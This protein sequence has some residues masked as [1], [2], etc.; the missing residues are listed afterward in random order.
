MLAIERDRES[1]GDRLREMVKDFGIPR[2]IIL[3]FLAILITSAYFLKLPMGQILSSIL[4]R[5]GMNGVLVLAMIPSIQCGTGP[6]FALPLGVTCGI[7]A[8]TLSIELDL[9]GFTAFFFALLVAI[10]LG[11][12]TG[13][14]YGV[15]LN[16]VKGQELTVGTYFGF[17]VVSLMCIFWT[18]VPFKSP[19]MIWPYGG[20]GLRVTI[21]LQD[22]FDKVLDSFLSFNIGNVVVPTGLL[23]FF[24]AF[25]IFIWLFNRSKT[26]IA[27]LTVGNN[28]RF[29]ES[30]GLNVNKYRIVGSVLSNALAAVGIVVYA[31]S[32]GFL[33]LYMAPLFM[34]FFA[35][36]SILIGGASLR[37]ATVWH[38]II[39]CFLF[40][41][42]LVVSMPVAN[43]VVADNL[44]EVVRIIISN[45]IIL[46]ALTRKEAGVD[47]R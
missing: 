46:Y 43:V 2:L 15:L 38:A 27:M 47:V 10:P 24:G 31:Q 41:S 17:S 36:A 21:S 12:L 16:R 13:Y 19:E 37:R 40:Q 30:S 4:T 3:I 1:M 44:A 35:V 29:A 18:L 33:Q 14:L 11:A 45:G 32:F 5:F 7:V 8:A 6:N 9:V 39:G 28:P 23:L 25:C 22:R 34:A 42:I 26:G 20:T